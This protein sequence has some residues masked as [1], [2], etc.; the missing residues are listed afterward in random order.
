MLIRSTWM[1]LYR[2]VPYDTM[3]IIANPEPKWKES[4]IYE[5][6][7]FGDIVIL[8]KIPDDDVTAHTI[9]TFEFYKWLLGSGR[10]YEFVTK[11]DADIWLN[12]RGFYDRF[13]APRISKWDGPAKATVKQTVIGELFYDKKSDLVYPHHSM[14]TLTWDMVE[15]LARLQDKFHL[16]TGEDMAISLLLLR[17]KQRPT[18][19]NFRG[20]EKFDF[21]EDDARGDGTAWAREHTQ[22][23][24]IKHA[25][26]DEAIAIRNLKDSNSWQRVAACFDEKG[27]RGRP[28]MTVAEKSPS[29]FMR[30][31]DLWHRFWPNTRFRTIPESLFKQD[32]GIWICDGLWNM[33]VMRDGTYHDL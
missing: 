3:F 19:V 8:D 21:D 22:V 7:T 11:L 32:N 28:E 26:T 14:Y 16:V 29:I 6:R 2:N 5:N 12:A 33:G 10:R 20:R 17:D 25:V 9:K 30:I 24:A 15:L 31:G 23:D 4:I 1:R 27:I 13:L 18:F